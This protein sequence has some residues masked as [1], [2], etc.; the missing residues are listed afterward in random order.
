MHTKKMKHADKNKIYVSFYLKESSTKENPKWGVSYTNIIF[1]GKSRKFSTE[2]YCD[3]S[4][5]DWVNGN[6]KGSKYRK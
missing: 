3:D 1:K 2:L 6:F 4:T 5:K